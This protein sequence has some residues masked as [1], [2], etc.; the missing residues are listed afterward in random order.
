MAS[1]VRSTECETVGCVA[2]DGRSLAAG[3]STGGLTRKAPGRVGDSGII[4]CGVHADDLFGCALT[5]HG[6]SALT[7]GLARRM[8]DGK[9]AGASAFEALR[10]SLEFM[11]K[12]TGRVAGAIGLGSDGSWAMYYTGSRMPFAYVKD[13]GVVC[14][15]ELSDCP[16]GCWR[17]RSGYVYFCILFFLHL[18]TCDSGRIVHLVCLLFIKCRVFCEHERINMQWLALQFFTEPQG[19][20]GDKSGMEISMQCSLGHSMQLFM[21]SGQMKKLNETI[22]LWLVCNNCGKF[23][24]L[25]MINF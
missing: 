3:S 15:A 10:E 18:S 12:E 23:G 13:K 6:E 8:A 11:K 22:K 24:E 2:W 19:R 21:Y 7:L 16:E 14:G 9:R 25:R 17:H 1:A 20:D 4:G 5:G